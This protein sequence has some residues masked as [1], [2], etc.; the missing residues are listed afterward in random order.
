MAS[1]AAP[2][3]V[4]HRGSNIGVENTAQAFENGARRGYPFLETD[5]RVSADTAFIMCHD[6][7]NI[8]L[9]GNDTIEFATLP[10][11][12]ATPLRQVRSSVEY[13][14]GI[15]TLGEYLDI[16]RRYGVRPVIELKWSRGINNDDC[17]LLPLLLDSIDAYGFA[18]KAII[19][20]SM[21]NCLQQARRL[22]PDME[23]QFLCR[24]NWLKNLPWADSLRIDMDIAHT[25]VDSATVAQ[26]HARG[27]KVNTWTVDD[28]L[29]ADSLARFGVDFITT[30]RLR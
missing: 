1:A 26:C 22:R 13:N 24:G 28:S 9:G 20:T 5:L 17:S 25:S 16:C 19:M 12:R 14:A 23:L 6:V 27:L 3:W 15:C 30:N 8:R 21:R 4:G 10:Q 29:R 11:L 18:D 7:D 2:L